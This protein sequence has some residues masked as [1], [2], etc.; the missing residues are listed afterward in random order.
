MYLR[1][2]DYKNKAKDIELP[3]KEIQT[4]YVTVLTGDEVVEVTFKD[5]S[6]EEYDSSDSRLIDYYDGSYEVAE[7]MIE[8]WM[9]FTPS[10]RMNASYERRNQFEYD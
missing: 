5:G 9:D 7:D 1:I 8:K 2:Y 10:G 3:D 4:I 6:I